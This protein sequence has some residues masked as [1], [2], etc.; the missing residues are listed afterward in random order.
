MT[1]RAITKANPP[2]K[3]C[4][5]CRRR[6]VKCDLGSPTCKR[7]YTAGIDCLGYGKLILWVDG[8]A[9]RGKMMGKS[10]D[11]QRPQ[12]TTRGAMCH[13]RR[14]HELLR[15]SLFTAR[16]QGTEAMTLPSAL[17]DPFCHQFSPNVRFYL[18]HFFTVVTKDLVIYHE[19]NRKWNPFHALYQFTQGSPVLFYIIIAMSSYHLYNLVPIKDQVSNRLIDALSAKD[20]ALRLLAV[21][22]TDLNPSNST[23]LL[24]ASML[25]LDFDLLE[26]GRDTWCIHLDAAKRLVTSTSPSLLAV[27]ATDDPEE[28][29]FRRW[30]ITNIVLQDI[31]GSTLCGATSNCDLYGLF[32]QEVEIDESL[33]FA[34]ANH[35]LSC[36]SEISKVIALASSIRTKSLEHSKLSEPNDTYVRL[37]ASVQ[38]FDPTDWVMQLQS[39]VPFDNCELRCCVGSAYKAAA[40]LYISR[41][42]PDEYLHN[43]SQEERDALVHE[44]LELISCVPYESD[45]FKATIWPCYIAG[46]EATDPFVRLRVITHL[47]MVGKLIPWNTTYS[48]LEAL[49]AVWKRVDQSEFDNSAGSKNWLKA[50]LDLRQSIFAG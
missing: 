25:L 40:A 42:L 35:Y 13:T 44:I 19:P 48:A 9:S 12:D 22:L 15:N 7:C 41:M 43:Y 30:V 31:V 39:L 17:P 28:S 20:K 11:Q 18:N 50:F 3:A 4:H 14:Q 10:F 46:A 36:P 45:L 37:L 34:E 8:V 6:R 29:S 1:D 21:G 16:R 23:V 38:S 33:R 49:E 2:R 5:T 32:A 27:T 26:S 24:T 47:Q